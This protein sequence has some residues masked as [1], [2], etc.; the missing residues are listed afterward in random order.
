[1]LS[2]FLYLGV[3][4]TQFINFQQQVIDLNVNGV[5]LKLSV[6]HRLRQKK[7]VILFL[8]GF[9]SSKEDYANISY[10]AALNDYDF[11]AYDAP[12][13]AQ[14]F[15][16]S[17]E[18][19]SIEFL[20]STAK[21]V[22]AHYEIDQFHVVGHSMG[23]LT[24]LQLAHELPKRVLSFTDIEGN[25]APE[26]CFLSRQIV[27]FPTDDPQVFLEQF[28]ER[29]RVS[30]DPAAALY[31]ANLKLKV[32]PTSIKPVFSSMVRLSDS[33]LLMDQFLNLPCPKMF[34]YGVTNRHLSYLEFIQAQGIQLAEIEYCGH[35]PMYSN[36]V[37]MWQQI[38]LNLRRASAFSAK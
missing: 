4:M 21:S 32:N 23:G 19:L 17:P 13:F 15:C 2:G 20:V 31:A 9:G 10:Y 3:M 29:V 16:A 14:S 6:I 1:M 8:H 34:M 37:Q 35:F 11:I 24:A 30:Y 33:G 26:D 22:L 36:P 38:E 18:Q 7:N 28:I 25:I 12:G 5:D 27:Q